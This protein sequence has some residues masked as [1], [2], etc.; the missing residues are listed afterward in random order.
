MKIKICGIR[1]LEDTEYL[2]QY[3]P[4]YAG[5]ILSEPFWRYVP[6]EQMDILNQ[7]LNQ[8]IKRV[9]VFVNPEIEQIQQ[10][11]EYLDIIQLH[12]EESVDMIQHIRQ[13][14]G[15]EIWKAARVRTP[16]DIQQA[17]ALPVDKLVLDSYSGISHG[18]TGTLA[19]WELIAEHKPVKP[20]FL[21]GGISVQNVLEAIEAVQPFGIDVS[22]SVET[23]KRKDREKI[24]SFIQ[25]IRD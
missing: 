20:F 2:N 5:F 23:D 13:E 7:N 17:D 15:M 1:R 19:P 18:G 3:T 14:T 4:D 10:Y 25:K 8:E 16:E 9:G 12:G 22:S 24:R 21:A 6:P 11:T